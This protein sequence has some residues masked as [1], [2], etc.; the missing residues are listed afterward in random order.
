M[1]KTK[2]CKVCF[3][4]YTAE[5]RDSKTCSPRCRKRLERTRR[6]VVSETR[7]TQPD[8]EHQKGT[9]LAALPAKARHT[10]GQLPALPVV[11]E[12]AAS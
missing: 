7:Y 12:E 6:Y 5:R 3:N 2:H 8:N 4:A 9:S 11:P 10:D 1:T